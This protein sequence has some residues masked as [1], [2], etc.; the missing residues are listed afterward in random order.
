MQVPALERGPCSVSFGA[1]NHHCSDVLDTRSAQG[2]GYGVQ[3]GARGHHIV[4]QDHPLTFQLRRDVWFHHEC[5]AQVVQT[6]RS[7]QAALRGSVMQA[8]QCMGVGFFWSQRMRDQRR[9]VEPPFAKPLP[10]QRNAEHFIGLS[11]SYLR[12]W[13][14]VQQSRQGGSPT[15]IFLKLQ[16]LDRLCPRV[17]VRHGSHTRI[18]IRGAKHAI[19]A[20][21]HWLRHLQ[22]TAFAAIGRLG[23]P[24]HTRTAYPLRR[25]RMTHRALAG[26]VRN[27][28]GC[29]AEET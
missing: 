5:V 4:H 29:G 9:L 8:Q 24:C 10:R 26:Y 27:P 15:R 21:F 18:Q 25:P 3:R 6:L 14:S 13:G 1:S 17:S 11:D 20:H 23:K 22:C 2:G 12:R 16:G 7:I 19:T 28:A